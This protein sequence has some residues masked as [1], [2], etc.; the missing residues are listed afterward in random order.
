MEKRPPIIAVMGH[1]D[2]G[3]T[4]LLD[5]IRK[6]SVATRE[7][8]GITQSIGS[9]E[10]ERQGR[11]ITFIDTPGHEAF[12]AMRAHS[13]KVA[14]IAILVVAA[15][16]GV[17]PQTLNALQYINEEKIPFVVAVNKIDKPNANVE[18]TKSDLASAGVYLEGFGGDVSWQEISAKEGTGVPELLDLVLLAS[19]LLELS[20]DPS[21]DAEGVVLMS[22]LDRK[23]GNIVGIVLRNG[24][25]KTGEVI[26]TKSAEGKVKRLVDANGVQ[27]KALVPSAPAVIL[28]FE[29]LPA[30][31]E[32]FRTGDSASGVK[33]ESNGQA[34]EFNGA[35]AE[36]L[37]LVMKADEAG[38]LE[39]MKN[40]LGKLCARFPVS[41]VFAGVGDV[42]EN[43]I[44]LAGQTK[45][46]V[47]GFKV[48]IDKAAVNLARGQNIEIVQSDIIYEL[49][50]ALEKYF[51]ARIPKNFRTITILAVFGDAKGK[52]RIVGGKVAKGTVRNQEAFELWRNGKSI[53]KGRIV[54]L[55][56]GR[57]DVVEA[58]EGAEVGLLVESEMMI[59][60]DD[61]L[62]F[63]EE[64]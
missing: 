17:K 5:H 11:K 55:Q 15:D 2:H 16:D 30:V 63:P 46:I 29:A 36:K 51:D 52:E 64:R 34:G 4:T 43:D 10:I 9:Y 24:T 54:N 61:E 50:K 47:L 28:G 62:M 45:G 21:A 38:S 41:V 14:D 39:A 37:S 3:K 27:V 6:T 1:V 40:V 49:E 35:D 25:L 19:D 60:E 13:A 8:G 32:I 20:Y 57:K 53:G 12:A 59:R 42:Y 18:K 48:K 58:P 44:K 33:C 22:R 26:A 7:A 23:Q 56:S 31:G